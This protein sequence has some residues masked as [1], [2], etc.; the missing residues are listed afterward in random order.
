MDPNNSEYASCENPLTHNYVSATTNNDLHNAFQ[1]IDGT[2][3]TNNTWTPWIAPGE[4]Y[5]FFI[6]LTTPNGTAATTWNCTDLTITSDVCNTPKT[7]TFHTWIHN[8]KAPYLS[9]Q[10]IDYPDPV[11]C[12]DTLHYKIYIVNTGKGIA[13]GTVLTETYD[14]YVTFIEATPAP[15]PGTN[16]VWTLGDIPEDGSYVIDIVV[17]L[18]SGITNGYSIQNQVLATYSGTYSTTATAQTLV[19]AFPDLVITKTAS[20]TSVKKDE[21][22]TYTLT[23]YN[24]GCGA[25]TGVV[26]DD[27]YDDDH[28]VITEDAGGTVTNG[29]ISW[30]IG[31]ITTNDPVTFSY[32]VQVTDVGCGAVNVKNEAV[33]SSAEPDANILD[34]SSSTSVLATQ[35]PTWILFPGNITVECDNVP[36]VAVICTAADTPAGCGVWAED[37][38]G[39]AVT[40]TYEGETR[41]DGSC[42]NTYTLVRTWKAVDDYGNSTTSTQTIEVVDTKPPIITCPLF[43]GYETSMDE[44]GHITVT[45]DANNNTTFIVPADD[46][47][48]TA[49]DN[50]DSE[51]DLAYVLTG[52]TNGSG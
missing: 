46:F 36:P 28:T 11:T 24:T 2:T 43:T 34:N 41:I 49:T 51:P 12:N 35:A 45:V 14:P 23:Y 18:N 32:T 42:A 19:N 27:F 25:A 9:V 48:A 5:A 29:K 6:V 17:E 30:F 31:E 16:N 3:I 50:C 20:A 4:A 7:E 10:K 8:P 47:D 13:T 21:Y 26:I 33:I 44:T 22:I 40:I 52:A 15:D 38:C 1:A 37:E 39:S